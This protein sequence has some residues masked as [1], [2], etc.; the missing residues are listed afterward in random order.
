MFCACV[1]DCVYV[2]IFWVKIFSFCGFDC[3]YY[4]VINK[5]EYIAIQV[6]SFDLLLAHFLRSRTG[7]LTS[8]VVRWTNRQIKME[9]K[10][11]NYFPQS[12]IIMELKEC[13]DSN[14]FL[15]RLKASMLEWTLQVLY[16]I[17][18][19]FLTCKCVFMYLHDSWYCRWPYTFLDLSSPFAPLWYVCIW[20]WI[21]I[22]DTIIIC[23]IN[24]QPPIYVSQ[25]KY[26]L[27]LNTGSNIVKSN[28]IIPL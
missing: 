3:D 16:K 7:N 25:I 28:T 24:L 19:P 9:L 26:N 23:H 15:A 1:Y 22:C 6:L 2:V 13:M 17:V 11:S 12:M 18:V 27:W 8:R 14:V 10:R 21:W 4:F 5:S 20:I